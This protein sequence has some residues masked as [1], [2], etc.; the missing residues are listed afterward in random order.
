M[1]KVSRFSIPIIYVLGALTEFLRRFKMLMT[2]PIV[3]D[4]Q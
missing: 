1:L 2:I 4:E 3:N